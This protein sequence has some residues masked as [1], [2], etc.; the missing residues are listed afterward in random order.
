MASLRIEASDYLDLLADRVAA[1]LG[2][3]YAAH[4]WTWGSDEQ[5]RVPTE[6]ELAGCC[7]DLLRSLLSDPDHAYRATGRLVV[8]RAEDVL[9][10]TLT[11]GLEIAEV[12]LDNEL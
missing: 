11:I 7:R 3:I 2:P 9:T 8:T 12:T 10:T 6:D 1:T 5:K 4:G